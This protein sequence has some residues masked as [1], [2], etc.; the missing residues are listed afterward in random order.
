MSN[1]LSNSG[2]ELVKLNKENRKGQQKTNE[3]NYLQSEARRFRSNIEFNCSTLIRGAHNKQL[4]KD[5][6]VK[7]VASEMSDSKE[8]FTFGV[9]ESCLT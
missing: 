6:N 2:T 8:I 7:T 1:F 4:T 9:S 3:T 5:I